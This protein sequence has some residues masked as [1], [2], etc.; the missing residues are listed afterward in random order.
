MEDWSDHTQEQD[1]QYFTGLPEQN[2]N[3]QSIARYC[4]VL[5]DV[6]AGHIA[7]MKNHDTGDE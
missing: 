2:A 1:L 7:F 6:Y 4:Q 5:N 3:G